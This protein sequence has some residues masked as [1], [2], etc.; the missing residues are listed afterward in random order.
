MPTVFHQFGI[1]DELAKD[2]LPERYFGTVNTAEKTGDGTTVRSLIEQVIG[3]VHYFPGDLIANGAKAPAGTSYT[4]DPLVVCKIMGKGSVPFMSAFEVGTSFFNPQ[5]LTNSN[6][7]TFGH[8]TLDYLKEYPF[9]TVK[10]A[11]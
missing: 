6:F 7:L 3:A 8:N 5:S 10:C 1:A 4:E 11:D 9:I 2:V